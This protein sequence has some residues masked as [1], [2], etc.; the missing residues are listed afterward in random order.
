MA[1]APD[2]LGSGRC[3]GRRPNARKR[4]PGGRRRG[5][6]PV[7]TPCSPGPERCPARASPRGARGP[8]PSWRGHHG[9]SG[10]PVLPAAATTPDRSTT[11]RPGTTRSTTVRPA[12]PRPSAPKSR[13]RH[14]RST[15]TGPISLSCSKCG[16]H[17]GVDIR[18]Y[19]VLHFPL[20]FWRPGRGYTS[21]MK[22]P[23]CGK[24]AWVSASWR[25]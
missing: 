23:A 13:R 11:G 6:L 3:S 16:T 7:E 20:W 18:R 17:T 19:L 10:P 12:R 25:R 21:L 1:D 5:S 24:R 22:C 9:R 14:R 15:V 8:G 2:P 4:D